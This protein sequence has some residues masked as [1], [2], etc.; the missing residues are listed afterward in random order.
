M[1]VSLGG[2][3]IYCAS[4]VWMSSVGGSDLVKYGFTE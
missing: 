3:E 1:S 2:G 4:W